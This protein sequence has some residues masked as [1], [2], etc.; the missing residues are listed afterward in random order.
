MS[1]SQH[2][3]SRSNFR[4]KDL[5][6]KRIKYY[7]FEG[8]KLVKDILA[9]G[10][11]IEILIIHE[12]EA[13]QWNIPRTAD[14]GE[15][16]YVSEMVLA[17]ISEL[18]DTPEAIAVVSFEGQAL[19][20]SSARLVIGVDQLQD[21]GNAGTLFRCA[22]AFE[23]DGVV[24]TGASVHFNNNKFLRAAQNAILEVPHRRFDHV[25]GLIEE[26]EKAGLNIY[27]TSPHS[28][29]ESVT[30]AEIRHPALILFGGEGRGLDESLLDRRP[31]V[32]IPQGGKI[33]SLNLAVSAC[34]IMS[35][36]YGEMTG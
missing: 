27:L 15:T 5:I 22:A 2:I 1:H 28:R 33:E 3:Q 10:I 8:E 24:F 19:D 36:L 11:P 23:V 4:V 7:F 17:K 25:D 6:K 31:S 35:H 26:A 30:P 16:W 18:K 9:R 21:P 20:F 14:I 34:I 32:R 12:Q 13:R 29:D